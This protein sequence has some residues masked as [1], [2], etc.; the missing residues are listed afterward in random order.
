MRIEEIVVKDYEQLIALWRASGGVGL[1][2]DCDS[3]ERIAIYLQRNPGLSFAAWSGDKIVGAVL[4]GH[5]GRRGYMHHLAVAKDHSAN[6]LGRALVEKAMSK[7]RM[8]GIRR[9]NIFVFDDNIAAHGF[10]THIGWSERNDIKV[11]FSDIVF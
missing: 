2:A 3:K 11:M 4:C 7:L 5:D 10:W 9:C 6:G 1:H 8:I